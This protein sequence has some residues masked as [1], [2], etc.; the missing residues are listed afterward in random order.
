MPCRQRPRANLGRPARQPARYPPC[1]AKTTNAGKS[2]L[3]SAPSAVS[4]LFDHSPKIAL[5]CAKHVLMTCRQMRYATPSGRRDAPWR[6]S[7]R[8]GNI[9]ARGNAIL[10]ITS[11]P[12]TG[13][14][15]WRVSTSVVHKQ[16]GEARM[17]RCLPPR[18]R[19]MPPAVP[20]ASLSATLLPRLRAHLVEVAAHQHQVEDVDDPIRVDVAA[21]GQ[22]SAQRRHAA[23]VAAHARK[24]GD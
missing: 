3:A 11:S 13:D 21:V 20:A 23:K 22:W 19:A 7:G 16:K 12:A 2:Y 17:F 8:P 9:S 24:V 15:P 18:S 6:V 14:A 4:G 5:V 10:G 1:A